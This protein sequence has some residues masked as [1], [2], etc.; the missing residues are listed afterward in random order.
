MGTT[1]AIQLE[2]G[3]VYRLDEHEVVALYSEDEGLWQLSV[4][5]PHDRQPGGLRGYKQ[6]PNRCAWWEIVE[7][8]AGALHCGRTVQIDLAALE[9]IAD[10]A[11][12][13]EPAMIEQL[14]AILHDMRFREIMTAMDWR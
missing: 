8:D 9:K 1:R 5:A 3:A 7:D 12:D 11:P 2:E 14:E 13:S 4:S 6:W 10:H